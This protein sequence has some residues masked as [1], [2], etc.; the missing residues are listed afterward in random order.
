MLGDAERA[1]KLYNPGPQLMQL[2]LLFWA[3]GGT[4]TYINNVMKRTEH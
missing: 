4:A 2:T 3:R 1:V